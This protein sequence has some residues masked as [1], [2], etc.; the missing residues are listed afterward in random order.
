MKVKPDYIDLVTDVV[1]RIFIG[2]LVFITL[3]VT[4]W[5]GAKFIFFSLVAIAVAFMC[6]GVGMAVMEA[7]TDTIGKTNSR[8]PM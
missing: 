8:G 1:L 3:G 4:I 6:W 7:I 2:A 5:F